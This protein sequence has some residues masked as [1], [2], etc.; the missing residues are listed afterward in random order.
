MAEEGKTILAAFGHPDDEIW[1][2]GATVASYAAAGVRVARVS[3]TRGEVG[4]IADPA[5]ATRETLGA[6]REEELRCSC[7]ELG[8][9]DL[10]FL[11]YRDSGMAGSEDNRHPL[12]FV[13][14]P[15][16]EVVGKLVKIIRQVRPQVMITFDRTGAYGHPDHI[17]IFEAATAAFAQA[18]DPNSFP[19]Q[20]AEGLQPYSPAHLYY[21]ALPRT[22]FRDL[23]T[24]LKAMG[25]D[26]GPMAQIDIEQF[27]TPDEEIRAV[28]ETGSFVENKLRAFACH[29]TQLAEENMFSRLP[30]AIR[31]GFMAREYFSEYDTT[32]TGPLKTDLF[33]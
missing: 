10:F 24:Q 2:S 4:E 13:N 25:F 16:D 33:S 1:G 5:L 11:D 32:G 21:T 23:F 22:F 30:D 26:M 31:A 15:L 27:G 29:R 19:E 28:I 12:A 8:I 9:S 14:A 7:R 18:G 17:R 6:V 3:G 20:I